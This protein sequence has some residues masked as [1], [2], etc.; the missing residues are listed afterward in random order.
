M[1]EKKIKNIACRIFG[2]QFSCWTA[3]I[4]AINKIPAFVVALLLTLLTAQLSVP[5]LVVFAFC[6]L[7]QMG[8]DHRL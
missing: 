1:L 4:F 5:I 8:D 3:F 7:Y 2:R 6:V